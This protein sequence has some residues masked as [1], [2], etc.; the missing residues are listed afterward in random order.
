MGAAARARVEADFSLPRMVRRYETLYLELAR[1][2]R[3]PQ[4]DPAADHAGGGVTTGNET[5]GRTRAAQRT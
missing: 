2:R 3:A 1:A 4:H 5:A